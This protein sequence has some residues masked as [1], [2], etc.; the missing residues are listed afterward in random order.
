MIEVFKTT[1][2]YVANNCQLLVLTQ[3][4]KVFYIKLHLN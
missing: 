2:V 4:N 1:V 3:S